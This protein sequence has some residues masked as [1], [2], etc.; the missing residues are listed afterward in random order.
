[1][2]RKAEA[3]LLKNAWRE[4]RAAREQDRQARAAREAALK[5][6]GPMDSGFVE[7]DGALYPILGWAKDDELH[8]LATILSQKVSSRIDEGCRSPLAIASEIQ[9]MGGNSVVNLF[10][11]HGVGYQEIVLDVAEKIGVDKHILSRTGNSVASM[12]REIVE[13]LF[14]RLAEELPE[15]ARE[16]LASRL[17]GAADHTRHSLLAQA[18][19]PALLR[20][21]DWQGAVELAFIIAAGRAVAAWVPVVG[22]LSAG[23]GA[24]LEL[25]ATAYSV[26]IPCVVVVGSIRARLREAEQH[27]NA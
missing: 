10:R 18:V 5:A 14:A 13:L 4:E 15:S 21:C 8:L 27:L 20:E 2:D 1:M 9:R 12:E 24:L 16:H 25:S 23:A 3:E 11:G 22:W 6:S 26:T 19:L 7:N 17:A